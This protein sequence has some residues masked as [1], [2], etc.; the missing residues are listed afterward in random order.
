M[1]KYQIFPSTVRSASSVNRV[2]F[3]TIMIMF[4]GIGGSNFSVTHGFC[5]ILLDLGFVVALKN[6]PRTSYDK[7][8]SNP[9][10]ICCVNAGL[11][12]LS[13]IHAAYRNDALTHPFLP[14][15]ISINAYPLYRARIVTFVFCIRR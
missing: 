11:N 8:V 3:G 6:S 4:S 13:C 14:S 5:R 7:G 10:F 12:V 9:S 15:L 1:Q 2:P